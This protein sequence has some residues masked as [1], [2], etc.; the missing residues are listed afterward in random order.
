M[1]KVKLTKEEKK[2]EILGEMDNIQLDINHYEIYE[3]KKQRTIDK[4]YD[5][6]DKLKYKLEEL[7]N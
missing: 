5:R 7:E 6:M 4:L 2:Q 1:T 3:P